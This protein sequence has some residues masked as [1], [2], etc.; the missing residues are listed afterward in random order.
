V[1]KVH[2]AGLNPVDYK[3][4][5]FGFISFPTTPGLD[6][7]GTVEEVGSG[8]SHFKVGERVYYHGNM[9]SKFGGFAQYSSIEAITVAHIPEGVSFVEA[10]ALPTAGWTAYQ[11]LYDKARIRKGETVV[12]TAGSGGV[13]GFGI[14]LAKL[15]GANV[16]TTCSA[17]NFEFVRKLGADHVIDYTKEDVKAR[18]M[19]ITNNRGVDVWVDVIGSD[20]ADVGLKCLAFGGALVVV[21]G[22]PTTPLG[23]LFMK[24]QTVHEAFLG[25]AHKA[26]ILAR[27]NLAK[28]GQ[29]MI[30]LLKD[31]KIDPLVSEVI[32][33]DAIPE[34]LVRIKDRHVT[35]KIVANVQ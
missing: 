11:V 18:V 17:K 10:A 26:D 2:A 15:A 21:Q 32:N 23:D 16:I 5:C 12:I 34:A 33:F 31:K 14:Q 3:I 28:T 25:G 7:A 29:E 35:G 8:V 9:S 1:V 6:I 4:G 20:S 30:Q 19:E 27:Q 24:Q 13:G 22:N